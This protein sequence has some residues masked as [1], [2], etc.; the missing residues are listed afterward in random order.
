MMGLS[1]V[2][3][4]VGHNDLEGLLKARCF[5][6]ISFMYLLYVYSYIGRTEFFF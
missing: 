1:R 2:R 3:L 4:T 6:E 5:Y